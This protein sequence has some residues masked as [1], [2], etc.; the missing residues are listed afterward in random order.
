[1]HA[2]RGNRIFIGQTLHT[3]RL[4]EQS[5]RSIYLGKLIFSDFSPYDRPIYH[6]AKERGFKVIHLSEEGAV[7]QGQQDEGRSDLGMQFDPRVLAEDDYLCT[8]GDFQHEHYRSLQPRSPEH[9]RTTGY[10]RFD[11]YR[12]EFCSLFFL[13]LRSASASDSVSSY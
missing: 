7:F 9:M 13:S 4:A 12:P 1:M 3:Y 5:E 8:W 2:Y 6:R 10:P 11:L